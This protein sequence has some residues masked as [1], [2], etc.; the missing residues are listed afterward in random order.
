MTTID[1]QPGFDIQRLIAET[2]KLAAEEQKLRAEERKLE[3]ETQKLRIDRLVAPIA[4][5]GAFFGSLLGTA[6]LLYRLVHG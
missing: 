2:L 5:A 1:E 4:L 3:A 6:A